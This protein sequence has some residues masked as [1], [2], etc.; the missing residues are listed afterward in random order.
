[1]KK[2]L[3][4]A[5]MLWHTAITGASASI[6]TARLH[7]PDVEAVG[8]ARLQV[9]FWK[10]YDAQLYAPDGVW[11][12]EQPYALS[13]S[14]LRSFKGQDIVDRSIDEIASQGFTDSELLSRWRDQLIQI[15]PDVDS[16]TNITGVV[17]AQGH[18]LFYKNGELV[19]SVEDPLFSEKFFGI[20]L[21]EKT[22]EPSMRVNLIG[23]D[24]T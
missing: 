11:S 6:D 20:W 2:R 9:L 12:S 24:Q 19:G 23:G 21:S 15:I 10:I 13:L 22:S 1:M 14:Y 3:L 16:K 5:V 4:L 17:D 18:S 7:I 8:S